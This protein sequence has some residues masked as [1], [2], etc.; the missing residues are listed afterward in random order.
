M[1]IGPATVS[2]AESLALMFKALPRARLIGRP[3]RGASGNPQPL[4]LANGVTVSFSRWV[5]LTPDG[6]PIETRGVQ[7]DRDVAHEV[8][9][10]TAFLA[11]LEEAK[12]IIAKAPA[13]PAGPPAPEGK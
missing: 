9:S 1:L 10:D 13:Q 4:A 2:S 7:P 11:A 12:A 6:T 8:D 3:T 5:N